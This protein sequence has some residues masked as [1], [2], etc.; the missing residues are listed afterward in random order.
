MT[1]DG[2][3]A[4][5]ITRMGAPS[6]SSGRVASHCR[7]GRHGNHTAGYPA[8]LAAGASG[9]ASHDV[10][11]CP[12]VGLHCPRSFSRVCASQAGGDQ[13]HYR[14]RQRTLQ[15]VL[16]HPPAHAAQV[17]VWDSPGSFPKPPT[18]RADEFFRL[19][20]SCP[21]STCQSG[22]HSWEGRSWEADFPSGSD[23]GH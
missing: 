17:Y 16:R 8:S 2:S 9:D 20:E 4:Q 14:I 18:Y 1:R 5:H 10:E 15:D 13:A 7:A 22:A 23:S 19:A 3:C 12:G 11:E 6:R 21:R